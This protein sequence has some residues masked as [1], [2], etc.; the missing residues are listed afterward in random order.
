MKQR[1]LDKQKVKFG[2]SCLLTGRYFD[3]LYVGVYYSVMESH[4]NSWNL[5]VK[6][7]FFV[8]VIKE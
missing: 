7:K 8:V 2:C 5:F 1:I 6:Y 3:P 4:H